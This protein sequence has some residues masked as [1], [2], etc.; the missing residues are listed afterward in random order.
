M[1]TNIN[2]KQSKS[3]RQNQISLLESIMEDTL[4]INELQHELLQ[5]QLVDNGAINID[6]TS[7]DVNSFSI[8]DKIEEI[9]ECKSN[10]TDNIITLKIATLD[11]SDLI[12]MSV[13]KLEDKINDCQS[14]IDNCFNE[15]GEMEEN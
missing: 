2:W 1:S 14:D 10:I 9:E 4:K 15:I 3:V 11:D 6:D 7:I 12:F 5:K 13:N 8:N